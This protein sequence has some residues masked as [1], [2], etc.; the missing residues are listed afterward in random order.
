M[1]KSVK[2]LKR[3]LAAVLAVLFVFL[4]AFPVF[5]ATIDIEDEPDETAVSRRV[6]PPSRVIIT[7]YFV[8]GDGLSA[9]EVSTVTFVLRNMSWVS[10][11]NSVLLTG[12]IESAAPVEFTGSNQVYID[13]IPPRGERLAVFE[14]YTRHVDMTAIS[15]VSAGFAIVYSDDAGIE[16]TSNVS[17]RLPVL[18]GARTTVSEDD[19]QWPTP[20]VSDR[21]SFLASRLMQIAYAGGFV[22]CVALIIIIMLFK[23]GILRRRFS[24]LKEINKN[25]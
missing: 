20:W 13:A 6:F 25:K 4:L 9:G 21:N 1:F 17:V 14:Y 19:M 16:R 15:T 24:K 2:L 5:A 11:V 12:W 3:I 8:T 22:F 18:R 23:I 10:A 7:D